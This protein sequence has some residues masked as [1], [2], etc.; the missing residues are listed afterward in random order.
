MSRNTLSTEKG[1]DLTSKVVQE[2][3][4]STPSTSLLISRR[5]TNRSTTAYIG[6]EA[7][8]IG[9]TPFVQFA[10]SYICVCFQCNF[11]M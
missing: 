3:D 6:P 5:V 7:A 8:L 11:R 4:R 9:W 10:F 1:H 2:A